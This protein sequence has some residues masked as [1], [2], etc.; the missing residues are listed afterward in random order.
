MAA[1]RDFSDFTAGLD[2]VASDLA[3]AARQHVRTIS[4]QLEAIARGDFASVFQDAHDDVT[5]EMFAPPEFPFIR[6][7]QG[8]DELN[9]AI[10]HNFG[11]IADQRPQIRETFAEGDTVILFGTERGNIKESGFR[12]H[13]EFVERFTFRDGRLASLRIV[14]AY[15]PEP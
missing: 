5:L 8:A 4:E 2:R 10:V 9:K 7:A 6:T 14:A 1:D 11:A 15:C 12:Y 13:V 3:P